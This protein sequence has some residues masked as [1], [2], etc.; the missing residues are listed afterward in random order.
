MLHLLILT[1]LYFLIG[2]IQFLQVFST[3]ILAAGCS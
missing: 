3:T 2:T 1:T